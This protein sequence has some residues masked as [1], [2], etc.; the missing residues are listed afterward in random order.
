EATCAETAKAM[1]IPIEVPKSDAVARYLV[2]RDFDIRD[3][4]SRDA[5]VSPKVASG[6][7][8][9]WRLQVQSAHDAVNVIECR[10]A[11]AANV[12]IQTETVR[13]DLARHRARQ[14]IPRSGGVS[15][16]SCRDRLFDGGQPSPIE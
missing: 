14:V 13:H 1:P 12:F 5:R 7:S 16:H 6:L 9:V 11:P 4:P 10:T 2:Q 8:R 15:H 3:L